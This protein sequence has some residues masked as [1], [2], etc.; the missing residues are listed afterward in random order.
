[1]HSAVNTILVLLVALCLCSSIAHASLYSTTVNIT[2][3]PFYDFVLSRQGQPASFFNFTEDMMQ[4]SSRYSCD[5]IPNTMFDSIFEGVVLQGYQYNTLMVMERPMSMCQAINSDSKRR[6]RTM[7]MGVLFGNETLMSQVFV[8]YL[9]SMLV[10]SSRNFT[11]DFEFFKL[12][13]DKTIYQGV[14]L[15]EFINSFNYFMY[16][17]EGNPY[18]EIF[19]KEWLPNIV[20]NSKYEKV[21]TLDVLFGQNVVDT[22]GKLEMTFFNRTLLCFCTN[23]DHTLHTLSMYNCQDGYV[24]FWVPMSIHLSLKIIELLIFIEIGRAHV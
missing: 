17:K 2:S 15:Y 19:H 10:S 16:C 20:R 22:C 11:L 23:T 9:E 3:C 4:N 8:P 6:N 18:F 7:S 24:T 1:M 14:V 13:F 12:F 21:R 5:S